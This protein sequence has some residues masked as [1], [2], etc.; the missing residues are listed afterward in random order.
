MAQWLRASALAQDP[1]SAC[2]YSRSSNDSGLLG[3]NIQVHTLR[4]AGVCAS[5][6]DLLRE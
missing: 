6:H 5:E 4:R 1:S 3:G 2:N